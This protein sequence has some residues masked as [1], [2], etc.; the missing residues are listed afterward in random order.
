MK[1]DSEA[2]LLVFFQ[3]VI[4]LLL[5]A[6]FILLGRMQYSFSAFGGGLVCILPT[7]YMY[8]RVFYYTGAKNA[9]KIVNS[10][11]IGQAMKFVL[12]AALFFFFIKVKWIIPEALFLGFFITQLS[13]WLVPFLWNR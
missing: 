7:L 13:C 2:K 3:V 12:T 5:L 10:M 11:Y 4:V 6:F 9:K 8:K 1:I